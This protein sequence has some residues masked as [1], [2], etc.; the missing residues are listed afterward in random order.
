MQR[1]KAVVIFW[2]SGG[3][4]RAT[5]FSSLLLLLRRWEFGFIN[6]EKGSQNM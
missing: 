5:E 2:E 3:V 6:P 4:F 1:K